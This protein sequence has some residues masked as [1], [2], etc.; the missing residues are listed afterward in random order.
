[1]S[2]EIILESVKENM[3]KREQ[4]T[5]VCPAVFWNPPPGCFPSGLQSA[6]FSLMV[7]VIQPKPFSLLRL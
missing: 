7:A 2:K 3:I 5:S 4:N 1:M 6:H